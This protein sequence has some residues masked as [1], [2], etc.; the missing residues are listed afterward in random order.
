MLKRTFAVALLAAAVAVPAAAQDEQVLA[1]V[2]GTPVTAA[3]VAFA[4]GTLGEAVERIPPA[5]R[6]EM[7]LNLLID[8][9]LLADAAEAAGIA[10]TS[11]YQQRIEYA[12]TQALRDLYMENVVG[13]SITED[14]VRARYDEEA[15]KI[16]PQQ[17]VSARH[18]LVEDE[19]EA[20]E[21][22]A[23]LK[24]GA[25]F[26]ALAAEHSKD[27]GSGSRGGS[28]GFFGPG[29]MVKPFE[30]AAFALEA[31]EMTEEPVQSQFGWHIIKVDE[32]RE[33]AVPP[34]EQIAPQIQQIMVREAFVNELERLK[35]D[36]D[37]KMGPAAQ[38]AQ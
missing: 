15:A 10:D 25:D 32:K 2:N 21:L 27:P 8:M 5:Q 9:Q 3:D 14:A 13:A 11:E 4:Y 35:A 26:A 20:K 18:I 38:A 31:G 29:Q 23:E 37:I 19:A 33:Q 36:A 16:E 22:I 17:Q 7:V 28:L 12:R 34:F 30:D 6:D 24:A 1:T